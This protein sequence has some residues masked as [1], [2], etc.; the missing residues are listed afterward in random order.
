MRTGAKILTIVDAHPEWSNGF[1]QQLV[2]CCED[3]VVHATRKTL[4]LVR[5]ALHVAVK[6]D[7]ECPNAIARFKEGHGTRY[8][9]A[10]GLY[11]FLKTI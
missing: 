1:S 5:N 7:A 10:C 11:R 9:A 8:Y 4:R 2:A 3:D 6:M